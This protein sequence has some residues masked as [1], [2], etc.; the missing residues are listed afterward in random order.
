MLLGSNSPRRKELLT[1]MGYD[2]DIVK[3]KCDEDFDNSLE[4][5]EVAEFLANKK[6]EAYGQLGD[7]DLL[8]TA[9]TTVLANHKIL[10]KPSNRKDAVE[11]L[12]SLSGRIH[13]VSTGVCLRTSNR[14]VSFNEVTEVEVAKLS[15]QEISEY[16]DSFKPY[17]KAGAYGIQEWFGLRYVKEVRGCYFNVVGLPTSKVHKHLKEL[18][19]V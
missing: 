2:F 19:N 7:D 16:V 11:M 1:Q 3:I 6:S 8:V 4:I 14:L 15:I 5:S 12:K 9:D 17:D 18:L 10:N 13:H